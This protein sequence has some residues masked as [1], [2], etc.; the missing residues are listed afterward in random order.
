MQQV[1]TS[2]AGLIDTIDGTAMLAQ[3]QAWSA[4]NTGTRN[5]AGLA[6]QAAVLA[7]TFASLPGRLALVEPAPVTAIAADGQPFA[8]PHGAHLL[9]SCGPRRNGGCC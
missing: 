7:D 6:Q 5:L 3:V 9:L 2:E 4:I 8:V 1:S